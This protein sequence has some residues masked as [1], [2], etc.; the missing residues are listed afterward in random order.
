MIEGFYFKLLQPQGIHSSGK[1]LG[2]GD[3]LIKFNLGANNFLGLRPLPDPCGGGTLYGFGVCLIGVSIQ[4]GHTLEGIPVIKEKNF[5]KGL[6]YV[7]S[8][9]S[10]L[11]C[12]DLLLIFISLLARC[13]FFLCVCVCV[14]VC[15][16]SFF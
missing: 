15:I 1:G 14:C 16:E 3:I 2:F 6:F 4:S 12:H 9:Y 10:V 8:C 5:R 13:F 11:V 7:R